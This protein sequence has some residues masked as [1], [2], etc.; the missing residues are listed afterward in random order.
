MEYTL[1]RQVSPVARDG[2]SRSMTFRRWR[3]IFHGHAPPPAMLTSWNVFLLIYL[4]IASVPAAILA[5]R[6]FGW[7]SRTFVVSQLAAWIGS[8]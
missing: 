5:L 8:G 7:R 1:L 3:G 4:S 6:G 2:L